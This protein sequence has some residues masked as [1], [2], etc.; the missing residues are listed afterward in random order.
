ML[1]KFKRNKIVFLLWL[2]M[3]VAGTSY[4]VYTWS[5]NKK[6]VIQPQT[7]TASKATLTQTV[8]AS[9]QIATIG[10]L[11]ITTQASGK[12]SKLYVTPGQ[13]LKKGDKIMDIDPSS[14][15]IQKRATAWANYLK[16]KNDLN[17]ANATLSALEA[18]KI[19]AE[20]KLNDD[21]ANNLTPADSAYAQ[22]KALLLAAQADYANQGGVIAQAKAVADGAY[23]V[24]SE[25]SPTVIALADGTITDIAYGEGSYI[26]AAES[27]SAGGSSA[28]GG[29]ASGGGGTTLA[30]L[31]TADK[32]MATLNV[33]ELDIANVHNGQ[34]VVLTMPAISDKTY[35]G[36]VISIASTGVTAANVISFAVNVEI[37]DGG[38]EVLSGMTAN[39]EITTQ[40]KVDALAIPN[41]AIKTEDGKHTVTLLKDGQQR[42]VP[43][44]LGLVLD[45]KSEITSG[46]V[47]G[48]AVVIPS[49]SSATAGGA[50]VSSGAR[51]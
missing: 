29:G 23:T 9:G 21:V 22:D 19:A 11:P 17:K 38:P 16:A 49:S 6:E 26:A 50:P 45:T 2:L 35:H 40:T 47:E 5:H 8:S 25:T 41:Q 13:K 31:K 1:E 18:D 44:T 42:V 33:S 36:K 34:D 3:I 27:S 51:K 12:V 43:V 37:T 39:G 48:D 32:L 20:K 14:A 24:Y 10:Q 28:G 4:G 7:A 30:T 15:T 46:L